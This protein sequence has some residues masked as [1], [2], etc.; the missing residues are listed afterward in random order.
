MEKGKVLLKGFLVFLNE[1]EKLFFYKVVK[2]G[3]RYKDLSF[4]GK[5]LVELGFLEE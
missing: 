2:V 4:A 3:K 5:F 1:N